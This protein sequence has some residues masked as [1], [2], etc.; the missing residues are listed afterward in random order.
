MF[1][2]DLSHLIV[3]EAAS[4]ADMTSMQE[5]RSEV[6][7]LCADMVEVCW[8]DQAG[9]TQKA[10]GLLEDI[11]ASGACLQLETAVPLEAEIHWKSP[12]QEFAGRARYCVYREIG[13]FVG[14]EFE[15]ESRWS[16]ETYQPQHLLDLQRLMERVKK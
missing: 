10:T 8:K 6:R 16:K 4:A 13:Y 3:K 9:R 7:M 2:W 12:Q 5:R 15:P 14:V 11:S 1:T